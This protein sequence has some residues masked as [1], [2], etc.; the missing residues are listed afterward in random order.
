MVSAPAQATGAVQSAEAGGVSRRG[1]RRRPRRSPRRGARR[2]RTLYLLALPGIVFFAVFSYAPMVGVVVAFQNFDIS[3]GVFSSPWNGIDNFKFFFS[4]GDAGR[5]LFNTIFLNV[6]FLVATTFASV[7][8]AILLNEI[9]L[10]QLKRTLQSTIFLPY[11]ISPVVL[12]LMLQGFLAGVGGQHSMVNGW[13]TS[14]G[15]PSV[16]WYSTPGVWP[17]LLTILKVWQ[18]S[19]YLSIIY[20]AAITSIPEEV[21]EAGRIDGASSA[22]MARR[23]TLPLLIPTMMVLLLLSVGRI[24]YGDFGMIYAIVGD[25]GTLFSTTDVIDTYVF[26]ALRSLGDLGMTAAI[27]LFQSVVGFAL[28][29]AA[30]LISRRY[31]DNSR[32]F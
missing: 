3:K 9:R 27:G 31:S 30:I 8:L 10:R 15:L 29:L 2:D 4:S 16:N 5:I 17:W 14:F 12:S 13:L 23:I 28:V 6:L 26:R 19:G 22:Q 20:L 1:W 7:W 25:N 18:T 24:F 11:F 32:L 21:Y